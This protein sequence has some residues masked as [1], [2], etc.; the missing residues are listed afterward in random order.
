MTSFLSQAC[1]V[2]LT[3]SY[4]LFP[5]VCHCY[6]TGNIYER[7]TQNNKIKLDT[8]LDVKNKPEEIIPQ[9]KTTVQYV[10]KNVSKLYAGID[11]RAKT[12]SIKTKTVTKITNPTDN[13]DKDTKTKN[14]IISG[15]DLTLYK[16][17]VAKKI[18]DSDDY[19][20]KGID[21]KNKTIEDTRPF[22][23]FKKDTVNE[24]GIIMK[25]ENI[26]TI[27]QNNATGTNFESSYITEI[28]PKHDSIQSINQQSKNVEDT[29]DFTIPKK[30]TVEEKIIKT[31]NVT[32]LLRNNIMKNNVQNFHFP[33]NLKQRR[34]LIEDAGA[35]TILVN[36]TV[37]KTTVINKENKTKN[38]TNILQNIQ[39]RNLQ[40][41]DI[42]L[43]E[44]V[45]HNYNSGIPQYQNSNNYQ[46]YDL[47][48]DATPNNTNPNFKDKP[49]KYKNN[50]IN[51]KT[52]IY[53]Q[54]IP[55]KDKIVRRY[56][57]DAIQNFRTPYQTILT[58]D[59]IKK[60]LD[61]FKMVRRITHYTIPDFEFKSD[62]DKRVTYYYQDIAYSKLLKHDD[63][64]RSHVKPDQHFED[65]RSN[66]YPT[67]EEINQSYNSYEEQSESD[68]IKELNNLISRQNKLIEKLAELHNSD[69]Q[70][71]HDF[72]VLMEEVKKKQET[73][74]KWPNVTE[75]PFETTTE[76]PITKLTTT[77]KPSTILTLFDE[78]EVRH[79]LKNDPR[80]KRILKMANLKRQ[81]YLNNVRG[82]SN[83]SD[84]YKNNSAENGNEKNDSEEMT[85]SVD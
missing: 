23:V 50:E 52:I 46:K 53:K 6:F 26:P 61:E 84:I 71:P 47:N 20:E 69:V 13:I 81:K 76:M 78:T 67:D 42:S 2:N 44:N 37:G 34:E 62:I 73:Y 74:R 77:K 28:N 55:K 4:I 51:S 48:K 30:Y 35:F 82:Y 41:R 8:N 56:D 65:D 7:C 39:R 25:N 57:D 38:I 29:R 40:K 19:L 27:F 80:V 49:H 32:E 17:Q 72:D 14:F 12:A 60:S 36:Y 10:T 66:M 33:N 3:I 75:Y 59:L 21:N 43:R 9:T 5:D 64:D 16:T 63:E 11:K 79:A 70:K 45:V 15:I 24:Q 68:N 85:T 31:D 1:K 18:I 83:D 58:N 22:A 54:D